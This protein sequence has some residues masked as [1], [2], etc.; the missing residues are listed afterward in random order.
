[1]PMV[2]W[3]LSCL[4]SFEL[5]ADAVGAGHQHRLPVLAGQVEQAA[6]AANAAAQ[7]FRAESALDRGLMRSTTSLPASISTPASR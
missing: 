2:S 3:R 4:A 6:E 7:H 1:M 5:G